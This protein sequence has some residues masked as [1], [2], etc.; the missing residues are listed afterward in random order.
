MKW[1]TG[2]PG[3]TAPKP[4][5]AEEA[6]GQ[7]GRAA[8]AAADPGAVAM[9]DE[10]IVAGPELNLSELLG[11][12]SA[13]EAAPAKPAE[14]D[15][16]DAG[17]AEEFRESKTGMEE[18]L[19]EGDC[20]TRYNL[21]IAYKKAGLIDEAIAQFTLAARDER[22]ILQCG[23]MLGLCFMEKG[24]PERAVKWFE[25]ALKAGG[26]WEEQAVR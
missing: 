19:G 11:V 10:A 23:S 12:A 22:R 16:G 17:L 4:T 26:C 2:Q 3:P 7:P 13:V 20:E 25:A 9:G 8:E 5:A 14:T 15:L 6:V 18:Q 21:G 24:M 1:L